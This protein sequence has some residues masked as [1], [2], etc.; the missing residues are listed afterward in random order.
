ML[1]SIHNSDRSVH[2]LFRIPMCLGLRSNVAAVVLLV[3]GMAVTGVG[4]TFTTDAVVIPVYTSLVVF[5]SVVR[6]QRVNFFLFHHV[7]ELILWLWL[8]LEPVLG[9]NFP[10][11][12]FF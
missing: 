11:A 4:G 3:S 6:R 10:P 2:H 1:K 7:H 5:I 9:R 8:G 12:P